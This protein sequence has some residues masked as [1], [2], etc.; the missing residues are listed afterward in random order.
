MNLGVRELA[1]LESYSSVGD[2][3][4][5]YTQLAAWGDLYAPL[6][7]S[8]VTNESHA[9]ATANAYF[10]QE[11]IE[12]GMTITWDGL[13][14]VSIALMKADL[15]ARFASV[16]TGQGG[17]VSVDAIWG[18]HTVVFGE[19]GF[20]PDVWTI[21]YVLRQLPTV[22]ERDAFWSGLLEGGKLIPASLSFLAGITFLDAAYGYVYAGVSALED[23]GSILIKGVPSELWETIEYLSYQGDVAAAGTFALNAPSTNYGPYTVIVTAT[24]GVVKG[25]NHLDDALLDSE[26]ADTLIGFDGND[27]LVASLGKDRLYGGAGEDVLIG[28]KGSDRLIGGNDADEIYAGTREEDSAPVRTID[29]GDDWI[30]AGSGDDKVYVAGGNDV[31][32]LGDGDDEVYFEKTTDEVAEM[33]I[34]GGDGAD[35]FHFNDGGRILLLNYEEISEEVLMNLDVKA[36]FKELGNEGSEYPFNYILINVEQ[37]DKIFIGGQQISTIEVEEKVNTDVWD[38]EIFRYREDGVDGNGYKRFVASTALT[39]Q[40]TVTTERR[41]FIRDDPEYRVWADRWEWSEQQMVNS[42]SFEIGDVS[43]SIDGYVAGD[44]GITFIGSGIRS[45]RDATYVTSPVIRTSDHSDYTYYQSPREVYIVPKEYQLGEPVT[46]NLHTDDGENIRP[47][48][49]DEVGRISLELED[50]QIQVP[51]G[52]G[53]RFQVGTPS[54]DWLRG[55]DDEDSISGGDG[56]DYISGEGGSDELFGDAG[57]DL[58]YGG[59]EADIL[60]GGAG[61]DELWGEEGNDI[62]RGGAG[63]DFLFGVSGDNLLEGGE[64]TDSAAYFGTLSDFT[65]VRNADNSVTVTSVYDSTDVL[66]D[67]EMIVLLDANWNTQELNLSD[68]APPNAMPNDATVMGTAGA[69]MLYGTAGADVL[70]GDAGDDY[71]E[72]GAGSDI[73]SFRAG[74]GHDEID[75]WDDPTSTD[76]LRFETGITPGQV[77][78]ARGATDAWDSVL[79]LASGDS[80]T[81]KGGFYPSSTVIEEVRFAD[82]TVWT[83]QDIRALHLAQ[84]ATAGDD[85]INGFLASDDIISAGDGNDAVYG[86]S[87]NDQILGGAGDDVLFG[88]EGDDVLA[89]GLGNDFLVGGLGADTFVFSAS[90]GEDWVDDF[91]V[92]EDRLDISQFSQFNSLA[93]VVARSNEWEAGTTWIELDDG[94]FVRLQGVGTADLQASNFIFA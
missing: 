5:Y 83:A 85:V 74:D 68:L 2:R 14:Q 46:N 70:F 11:L 12:D 78:I 49:F 57:S 43:S 94:N 64:G 29:M 13:A 19:N 67:I 86:Y 50:F 65:F 27:I 30:D 26:K 72:G 60:E 77:T 45:E 3:I 24:E 28:G 58:I 61:N 73:Y 1:I 32:I 44:A 66:R 35:S 91:S 31:V 16:A 56:D 59:D 75:D 80:I 9:G 20:Q 8:V 55:R 6:A 62:L 37:S 87:G 17:N 88:D 36:L 84:S 33:V 15:T 82:N 89:G 92:S 4:G 23:W 48:N 69:D 40:T 52:P 54:D 93:D 18:Y 79:T 42:A 7:L 71:L 25:G 41:F 90:T 76:V 39:H 81:I 51:Q 21:D 22:E 10:M 47:D 38:G 63:D 34:W 53:P